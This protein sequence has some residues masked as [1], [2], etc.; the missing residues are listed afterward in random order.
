MSDQLERRQDLRP[1]QA[2]RWEYAPAPEARDVVAI[3][4]RYGLFI[5]GDFVEPR[6]GR[7]NLHWKTSL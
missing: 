3:K 4:P 1:D 6:S 2:R 7:L 5:G